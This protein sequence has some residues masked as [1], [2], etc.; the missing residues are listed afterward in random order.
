MFERANQ[1]VA[2]DREARHVAADEG[3]PNTGVQ[4]RQTA[5][6]AVVAEE[7]PVGGEQPIENDRLG[8]LLQTGEALGWVGR[9]HGGFF[10]GG[11]ASRFATRIRGLGGAKQRAK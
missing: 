4:T 2:Q 10:L 5:R 9:R 8:P 6:N 1:G 11:S 7:C 3:A